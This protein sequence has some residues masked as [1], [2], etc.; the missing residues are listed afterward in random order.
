MLLLLVL[1]CL[2]ACSVSESAWYLLVSRLKNYLVLCSLFRSSP[3]HLFSRLLLVILYS[4]YSATFYSCTPLFLLFVLLYSLF[5]YLSTTSSV[6]LFLPLVLLCSFSYSVSSCR[7]PLLLLATLLK[8]PLTIS[9]SL[10]LSIVLLCSFPPPRKYY[11][12]YL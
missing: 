11:C 10:Y 6:C 1:C 2:L 7:T 3:V 12:S 8:G 5:T 4:L 9:L